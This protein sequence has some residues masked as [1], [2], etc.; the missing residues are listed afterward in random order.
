MSLPRRLL[1]L[2]GFAEPTLSEARELGWV[3]DLEP[4]N[5]MAQIH[6]AT[7]SALSASLELVRLQK[8]IYDEIVT[9]VAQMGIAIEL[10]EDSKAQLKE[11]VACL[12][13]AME[14][15]QQSF[16]LVEQESA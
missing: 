5:P 16:D 2:F 3:V 1:I 10:R 8:E 7:E 15:A 13:A 14:V 11:A 6:I 4:L 9:G 12:R